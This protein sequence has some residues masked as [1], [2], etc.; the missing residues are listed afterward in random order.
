[1]PD[2]PPPFE[3]FFIAET[4]ALVP[5]RYDFHVM[6]HCT[7]TDVPRHP[8]PG[9]PRRDRR[10]DREVPLEK[11]SSLRYGLGEEDCDG[12]EELHMRSCGRL[13]C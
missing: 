8:H 9:G 13:M 6:P 10:R 1:M 4:P 5:A 3:A 12:E 7:D 11:W 2:D